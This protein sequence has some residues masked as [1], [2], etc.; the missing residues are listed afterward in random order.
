MYHTVNG[1][2]DIS[3]YLRLFSVFTTITG[4]LL[5]RKM[6]QVLFQPAKFAY[7]LRHQTDLMVKWEGESGQQDR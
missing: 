7:Q 1:I 3:E 4:G 6:L 5:L 2:V